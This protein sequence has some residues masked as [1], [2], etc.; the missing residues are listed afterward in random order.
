MDTTET[1][2]LCKDVEDAAAQIRTQIG[3]RTNITEVLDRLWLL[4]DFLNR[5]LEVV[6]RERGEISQCRSLI[7]KVVNALGSPQVRKRAGIHGVKNACEQINGLLIRLEQA[8]QQA[9][10][11]SV[12]KLSAAVARKN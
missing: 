3:N 7:S 12:W 10:D 8:T 5:L 6:V 1:G 11:D 2:R 9:R 4:Q